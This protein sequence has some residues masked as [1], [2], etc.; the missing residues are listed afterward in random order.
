MGIYNCESTLESALDSLYAQT[1]KDFKIIMCDDGSTDST[2]SIAKRYAKRYANIILLK[3]EENKGLNYTLNK[4]LTHV[5]TEFVARMDGDDISLPNRFEMQL[6]YL[7]KNPHISIV[8]SPMI[9]FDEYGDFKVGKVRNN[10]PKPL[11]F[12]YGTPFCHAPS[13]VRIEAY[14]AVEG[15]TVNKYLLR[16]EDFH[17]WG[18]MYAR[19]LRGYNFSTPLYKMRD[20]RSAYQRR[21][22]KNRINEFYARCIIFR[23]LKLPF[24]TYIYTF[25][26]ILTAFAPKWL[27]N[28]FHMK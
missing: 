16:V 12:I 4:C 2:Y 11:D 5:T 7:D 24:Y 21:T 1:Y 15:Y 22:F 26:P 10:N 28:Y 9:Y 13:M 25:R 20:D 6:N 8:S 14:L 27:Y 18:K 17:L 23:M 19:G 3:N